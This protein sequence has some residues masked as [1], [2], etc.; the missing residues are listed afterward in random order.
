MSPVPC[1]MVARPGRDLDPPQGQ[2]LLLRLFTS[3]IKRR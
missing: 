3:E 2:A 1:G